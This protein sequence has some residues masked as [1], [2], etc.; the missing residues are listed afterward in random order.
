MLR[1]ATSSAR[2]FARHARVCLSDSGSR[3]QPNDQ[4]EWERQV[5]RFIN[6]NSDIDGHPIASECENE[7]IESDSGCE[8]ERYGTT[9]VSD[10]RDSHLLHNASSIKEGLIAEVLELGRIPRETKK[11]NY[12]GNTR[13]RKLK[14]NL[15]NHKVLSSKDDAS[16]SVSNVRATHLQNILSLSHKYQVEPCYH[17]S[18]WMKNVST[19]L[20]RPIGRYMRPWYPISRCSA[21]RKEKE[22]I[23]RPMSSWCER[24]HQIVDSQPM[25]WGRMFLPTL[26]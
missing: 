18:S 20:R 13:E 6:D 10:N 23:L 1:I 9:A 2:A 5:R 25:R 24:A 17:Y 16:A 19:P 26:L 11:A 12:E 3:D 7:M 4:Q 22:L 8:T 14:K 21:E 15:R